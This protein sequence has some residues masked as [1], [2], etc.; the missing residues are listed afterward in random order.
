[1]SEWEGDPPAPWA[2]AKTGP[3]GPGSNRAHIS[4][5]KT[6]TPHKYPCTQNTAQTDARAHTR[7]MKP[8]I[9]QNICLRIRSAGR[10]LCVVLCCLAGLLACLFVLSCLCT[11]FSRKVCELRDWT[12]SKFALRQML[13]HNPQVHLS[14][15]APN[16]N[17]FLEKVDFVGVAMP[18]S[19]S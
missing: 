6:H 7:N 3:M 14:A 5:T 15:H 4:K 19:V 2:L 18:F 11:L 9:F 12:P 16:K 1:M 13:M 8:N 17:Y 10:G